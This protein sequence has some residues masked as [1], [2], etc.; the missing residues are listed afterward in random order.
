MSSSGNAVLQIGDIRAADN[1]TAELVVDTTNTYNNVI[2]NVRDGNGTLSL[3]KTGPG[4][5]TLTGGGTSFSGAIAVDEGTLTLLNPDNVPFS[6]FRLNIK[7]L[8]GNTPVGEFMSI[9]NNKKKTEQSMVNLG[10]VTLSDAN[11]IRRNIGLVDAAHVYE[12]Q[13]GQVS[14]EAKN[15]DNWSY[16]T[17]FTGY[18]LYKMFDHLNTSKPWIT[19]SRKWRRCTS[20]RSVNLNN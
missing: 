13:P 12:I 17:Q 8:A 20:K 9:T 18:E 14:V 2:A 3:R 5:L 1:R 16:W 7:E 15:S 10:E 4:A 19:S 11:G 6:W